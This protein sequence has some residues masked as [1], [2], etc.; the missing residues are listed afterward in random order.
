VSGIQSL[1]L[2][3]TPL[4]QGFENAEGPFSFTFFSPEGGSC[5]QVMNRP[6]KVGLPNRF[7]P[8]EMRVSALIVG[9][10]GSFFGQSPV[11][12]TVAKPL[13]IFQ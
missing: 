6:Q 5:L 4:I 8:F 9:R 7:V 13:R 12:H 1:R 11:R 2:H 10:N 3:V